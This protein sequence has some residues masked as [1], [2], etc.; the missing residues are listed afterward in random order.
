MQ[1]DLELTMDILEEY[2]AHDPFSGRPFR[3]KL[4]KRWE[5]AK[6]YYHLSMLI[7]GGY[8]E[9]RLLDKTGVKNMSEE[10]LSLAEETQDVL[11]L[12]WKGHD[13]LERL[14]DMEAKEAEELEEE[15]SETF[16]KPLDD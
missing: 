8:L 5:P 1:R 14:Q 10:S 3:E 6:L 11:M 12:T 7:R 15:A 13:L 2:E 4:A 16:E 9:R